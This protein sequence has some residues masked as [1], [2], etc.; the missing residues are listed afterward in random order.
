[1]TG[2]RRL[3]ATDDA[4]RRQAAECAPDLLRQ[5]LADAR[6]EAAEIL[7]AKLSAAMVEEVERLMA[8][9]GSPVVPL[10]R[11]TPHVSGWYV[12][13]ITRLETATGLDIGSGV[14]GAPVEVVPVGDLAA[15]VSPLTGTS[16]WEIEGSGDAAIEALAPRAR[17]HE[18]VLEHMMDR[19]AVL[20]L[21]F[22]V[23][24]PDVERLRSLLDDRADSF[25][26]ALV[27]L[28]GHGEWGLTITAQAEA[29][30]A[31][32]LDRAVKAVA[33]G[34]DYLSRRRAERQ[35]AEARS[36]RLADAGSGIHDRLQAI[37]TAATVHQGG[38]APGRSGQVVLR[39]SYLVRTDAADA[40]RLACEQL[41]LESPSELAL[42]GDLSG[43]WP[44][45]HFC[46]VSLDEVSA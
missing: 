28:D 15:V 5:V 10:R 29:A 42:T 33:D 12:Y 14:D 21:R 38:G 16:G 6:Q 8:D 7:R 18:A 24:Y 40:F 4:I 19:G 46:D 2:D 32:G 22:G 34:R 39:G 17:A 43:P 31:D 35:A 25:R 36:S 27:A 13:G 23:L 3:L 26:H 45:Y 20:P 37:C 9:R 30:E 11:E 41:L 1:M 44:P